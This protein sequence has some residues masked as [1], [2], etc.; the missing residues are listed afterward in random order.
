MLIS[1]AWTAGGR[2]EHPI[3]PF[4]RAEVFRFWEAFREWK[5]GH[6]ESVEGLT[7]QLAVTLRRSPSFAKRWFEV[8]ELRSCLRCLF[9]YGV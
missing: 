3:R 8:D 7:R 6:N 5:H 1:L 4:R 9:L 2:P